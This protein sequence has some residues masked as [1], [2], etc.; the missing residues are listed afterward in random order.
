M[1]R[2]SLKEALEH[3]IWEIVWVGEPNRKISVEM[4]YND[5]KV[6]T[7]CLKKGEEE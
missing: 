6:I 3:D 7:E 4:T 1:D 5:L 2:I